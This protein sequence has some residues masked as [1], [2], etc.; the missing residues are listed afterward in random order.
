MRY[1]IDYEKRIK[2]LLEQENKQYTYYIETM[3]CALNENDSMKYAGILEKMGFT[4]AN[5]IE[6]ANVVLFNTCCIRENAEDKL[7][8]RVGYL[9]TRKK[10]NKDMYIAIVGCM[11]EQGHILD[12]IRKSYSYVDVVLG[13]KSMQFFA[14][15]LYLAIKN[16]KKTQEVQDNEH[17]IVEDVPIRYEEGYKASISIIYG[18]NNFCS[19]CIV[20]YV[21]GRERSRLPEDIL[22]DVKTVASKG[23]KE[24]TLLGQNVNSYGNDF[25]DN[26][27]TFVDLLTE[28]EKVE[29]I[30]V[31]RFISPHP[32]DFT[33]ALI[34]K[35]ASSD[36]IAKQ[37]HLPLQSGSTRILES[38]NRKYT[39][40]H[41]L[42]LV[43]KMKERIPNVSFSTDIIVGFP[44]ETE[45]DFLDTMDVVEKVKFSLVYMFCYSI[46]KGTRAERMENQIEE[47]VKVERLQRLKALFEKLVLE[48]NEKKIGTVHK[49]LV[50]GLSKNNDKMYTGRTID[51][52]IVVFEAEEKDIGTVKN[53]EIVENNKWYLTGKIV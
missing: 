49:I 20:P 25:K 36:K 39:K 16:H 9:K 8:G 43:E 4:K 40:E 50:E 35:I 5:E 17:E 42:T 24:I 13:T 37:I 1:K 15:K 14:E 41:F 38:M 18:C 21:R 33:D 47:S 29:G 6:K 30:E 27:Y 28:I 32:K 46:R 12:K 10:Q 19:Y 44:G 11:T 2:E 3:G 7:F 48:D 23:Y 51:N 31:I 45:E 53:V 52:K 22:N 34:D 26:K